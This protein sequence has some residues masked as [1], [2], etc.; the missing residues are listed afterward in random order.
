M[1]ATHA[2]FLRTGTAMDEVVSARSTRILTRTLLGF[3]IAAA[4]F[5][6]L[7]PWQQTA[8]GD[9][10]VIAYAPNDRQQNIDA[11]LDGRVV[12]WHVGEGGHVEKGDPIVELSDNDPDIMAR[13]RTE[14]EAL[15]ARVAAA[16]QRAASN[17]AQLTSLTSSRE[18]AIR[19]AD[20]RIRMAK[21]RAQAA[22]QAVAAATAAL[23]TAQLNTARQRGLFDKG[24][25]SQR[26]FELTLLDE[27]RAQTEADRARATQ[28]AAS[29]EIA[30]I[31][32]ERAKIDTDGFA[33]MDGIRAAKAAAEADIASG[34]AELAR[35]DGRLARQATQSVR[36]PT[37]G[38]IHRV[39]AN[40]HTGEIVKA[41][42]VLAQI[43]PATDDRAVEVWINGND[44][45]LVRVGAAVRLQF[46]GW[47]AVQFAGWPAIAVG[48][49]GGTVKF[50]DATNNAKGEFRVVVVP[51]AAGW[52]AAMYLRQGVRVHAWVGLGR[53]RVGYELWRQWNG[54]PAQPPPVS[55]PAEKTSSA[56]KEK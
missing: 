21:Q 25:T 44:M 14:R 10:R 5:L 7:V 2:P 50:V 46:E 30:A 39:V 16:T 15:A 27:T 1:S 6:A 35:L 40:G 19:A 47:P 20:A 38:I 28:D 42:E 43:I 11:P 29:A 41:G 36:A 23:T 49:F 4:A 33:A 55:A 54:F 9:G 56:M 51:D 13:L 24:L 32:A 22:G 17:E 12:R 52:P 26:Q 37:A 8:K 18:S 31:T 34:N 3:L 48:T 53:V 45:P